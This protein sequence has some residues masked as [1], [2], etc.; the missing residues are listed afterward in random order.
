MHNHLWTSEMRFLSGYLRLLILDKRKSTFLSFSISVRIKQVLFYLFVGLP[1]CYIA[2]FGDICLR[3]HSSISISV[4][5]IIFHLL[6]DEKPRV[7]SSPSNG[8]R[9]NLIL[10]FWHASNSLSAY[11]WFS[12]TIS[13]I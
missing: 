3:N 5:T 1:G 11:C 7:S 2:P 13:S 12:S 4:F 10:A 6:P 8:I 9:L